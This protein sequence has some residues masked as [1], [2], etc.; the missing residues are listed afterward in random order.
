MHRRTLAAVTAAVLALGA[1]AAA[2]ANDCVNI[3][4][5]GKGEFLDTK[6]QWVNVGG[7]WLFVSPGTTADELPVPLDMPASGGNFT[8]GKTDALINQ[9]PNCVDNPAIKGACGEEEH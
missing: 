3:K 9:N 7:V 6:G 2:V 8:N 5:N 1:P 4:R